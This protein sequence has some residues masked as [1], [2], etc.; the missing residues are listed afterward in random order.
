[1]EIKLHYVNTGIVYCIKAPYQYIK[2]K[3]QIRLEE[4]ASTLYYRQHLFSQ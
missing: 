2:E 1:M 4:I 3:F